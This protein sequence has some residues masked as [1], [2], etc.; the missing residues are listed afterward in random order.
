MDS[1][2]IKEGQRKSWN[3]AAPGWMKW[4]DLIEKWANPA[5]AR[6]IELARVSEGHKSLDLATGI[7]EPAVSMAR[8]VG[9]NGSVL[10]TDIAEDMLEFGSQ[11]AKSEGLTNIEFKRV[12]MEELDYTNEFD[13]ITVRWGLMFLPD[14]ETAVRKL[15][16]A[17]KEGGRASAATWSTP[18]EVPFASRPVKALMTELKLDPPPAG[19]PGIFALSDKERLKS[20]FVDAGFKDVEVESMGLTYNYESKQE[21]IDSMR[22]LAAPISGI[23]NSQPESERERLWQLVGES[24]SDFE[25]GDGTVEVTSVTLLVSGQK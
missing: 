22:D 21:F 23:V 2:E 8:I 10:A 11:R 24:V 19:T 9:D 5:S 6:L 4:W 20:I 18:D 3:S 12:D 16:S 17:L 15:Y 14:P 1:K 7:G 13:S 25:K